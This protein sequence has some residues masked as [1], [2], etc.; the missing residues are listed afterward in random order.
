[1]HELYD[2][3]AKRDVFYEIGFRDTIVEDYCQ[4]KGG[5][6]EGQKVTGKTFNAGY[7]IFI[8]A[9]F[10]GLYAG[11]RRTLE[12][13]TTKFGQP[14]QFWGNVTQK[15]RSQY[16]RI[17]D[18]MFAA[19]ATKANV[20]FVAVDKGSISIGD[21]VSEMIKVMNEYANGGF[22]LMN[23]QMEK[24]PNYFFDN[25]GFLQFILKFAKKQ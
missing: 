2:A 10:L 23:S 19:A 7:E 12:G 9:F 6:A 17:R 22:Y 4:Y 13:E 21:A 16:S 1:M 25:M 20:D 18:Y 5:T 14:I 15:G 8:Y 24:I 3:W 11:E